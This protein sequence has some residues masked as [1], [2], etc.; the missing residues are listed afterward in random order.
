[1]EAMADETS[2]LIMG[3]RVAFPAGKTPFP[4]QLA[5]FVGAEAQATRIGSG[6]TLALLSSCLTFQRE[7]M[8]QAMAEYQ[9]KKM[10]QQIQQQQHRQRVQ[11][12]RDQAREQLQQ[13][14]DQ[15]RA[16]QQQLQQQEQQPNEAHGLNPLDH[17]T[18]WDD[19]A[20]RLFQRSIKRFKREDGTAP[21]NNFAN[22]PQLIPREELNQE[23]QQ[24][25]QEQEQRQEIK[26][27]TEIGDAFVVED[28]PLVPKIF[29]CSRT[30]SQLTQ[31]VNELKNCPDSYMEAIPGSTELKSCV[32]AS[33][34]MLCVNEEVNT[35]PMLVNE[36]CQGLRMEKERRRMAGEE[37]EE[38]GCKYNQTS[39]GRL[40][41]RAP[42]VWDI[43]D[44]K[45]LA[46]NCEECAYFFSKSELETAHVVFCPYNYILDPSIR[47]A[48]GI[49]LEN[50]IVVLDE[51][52][53]VE[54]TCR[55]GASLEL[56]GRALE[57]AIKSF[58]DVIWQEDE[59]YQPAA[60][61]A[62]RNMLS[63]VETWYKA[64]QELVRDPEDVDDDDCHLLWSTED[65]LEMLRECK[66]L[67]VGNADMME[68]AQHEQSKLATPGKKVMLNN[69]ALNL[70]TRLISVAKYMFSFNCKNADDFTLLITKKMRLNDEGE[71]VIDTKLCIWCLSAAVVFSEV[72][73]DSHSV[74]LAS[75]TLSP[76]D[77]FAGELGV[78]FPIRLEA[79]HV[80]NMRKQVFV[81]ALMNGPGSVDLLSTYKNQQNFKYQDS[82]GYLLL[83]Y[84]QMI[85][86]GILMFFPSYALMGILKARWKRSGIWDK[87]KL[88]KKIFSEPR[89]GGK[90][91]DELLDKFKNTIAQY[92]ATHEEPSGWSGNQTEPK[93]TGAIFL[94]VYRGKVSEGI[95]FSDDNARAV[96]AVGIP[97]PNFKDL[98]VSLKREYQDKK[99]REDRRLV[100]GSYWYKLQAFRA[101]NQALGRCIRHRRDYGAVLLLDSRHRNNMHGNSLSKWMRPHVQEFRSSEDCTH[102]FAE[103]YQRNQVELPVAP[104]PEPEPAPAPAPAAPVRNGPIVL[105]YEEDV[106]LK[107]EPQTV[108]NKSTL[109][110]PFISAPTNMNPSIRNA[111]GIT[112]ENSIVVLDEAHNVEDTCREGASLELTGRA[113]ESAIKSFDDVIWQEDESYQPAAYDA[114]R[115]MLSCVETWYKANQELVR[116]PEDVDDDDCHLLWSTEDTLEM[117]RECKLL[118]VG[119]ADM[120]EIAQHEQSK[121]ATPGKKVMLNNRALNLATRLISVAKYMF[122]FNCK[123][124]DDFTL[125]ITKKM[126]L[127]DEGEEVID[128][129]L[130]IWC[131][132][133]AVV[134]SEVARDSHSVILASGTL[135]PMDSFA[136]ELGVDFPIR[137]EANHVVN[138]RKQVFVGALMN[139][140]GS[141]DLLSTYKNQQNFKYQDSMG[142]LLLQY[143]QMIPGGILMFFPSYALMGI[144]KARWKRSGIWDKIKLHKKIFSEPRQGGKD[145]DELLDKFKNTIAQYAATHEEPS[146]WS[147]NQTE[148]KET[149]AIFLAVY[150]GKVSEGID[151]SD[152]NARAVLAVGIPFPN[153]KDLKVSLKREYQDKK[154][155]EDRRLVNG[156]YWYKLQAFRALNQALGRC[157]RHR[158]DYGAV[159]LLD[160][161]HRNNMHG[162]SLSKWMRPHVQEFRSSEDCT[163][164]FAEFYQRNQVEL[165]VA[166][167][168]EPE[169]APAPAPA[170]PVRNGPIVLEYE[171]DVPLKVEPQTVP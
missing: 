140:P 67:E 154:S 60:Y 81:G 57:S 92:A 124:A 86:G 73:R 46:S 93:E 11:Q 71:E 84:A 78:D 34:R 171:E 33:K 135:S 37:E 56:T 72:A 149:G 69:R 144:L 10:Q 17:T 102:L 87:I 63:C 1:M 145:F 41:A 66:L 109:P 62:V 42:H 126:R 125:L 131:L 18:G 24:Q 21:G 162:N 114:V 152:D 38:G 155:R 143:A 106:P 55:E 147:G 119:N 59:S 164:L 68:I 13:L 122:S 130:C 108:D 169:P 157:I 167:A 12:Q 64:N 32:L 165:P 89:Q 5:H 113:L 4:A 139:G 112:L 120:M 85:P 161:R 118:E 148:P 158:R 151:F 20:L 26:D 127:N 16:R 142:Y 117:L 99:S 44:I 163:H 104:A 110:G 27:E 30:H 166:P 79:N 65:T 40:R 156:S 80:V 9:Q 115:N 100:N 116:D 61:D 22:L 19:D 83:Q 137:L 170:A 138:M 48:V 51:A 82:M 121:L 101:L 111:V 128:T 132:S 14:R 94:A 77:S 28:K 95:D 25:A 31:A 136:G 49:T 15:L 53:N 74:I 7:H 91:F 54:D 43:E 103:F 98:K 133:A 52:H 3:H 159:L 35:D 8:T 6:K 150:R 97:F 107:V 96:L 23:N 129:K 36:K 50:S 2:V 160:S 39:F 88:H 141:V 168:P 47:N 134:F 105:E 76:M 75:G 153:F 45:K 58:D 146:G 123:N 29:F 90:D 70:A